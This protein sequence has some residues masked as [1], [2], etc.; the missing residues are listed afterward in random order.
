MTQ[1]FS[2]EQHST[3]RAAPPPVSDSLHADTFKDPETFLKILQQSA[4]HIATD[5]DGDITKNDLI[6]YS[7]S[8]GDDPLGKAAAAIAANHFD[9]LQKLSDPDFHQDGF[10]SPD[11]LQSDLKH[12]KGEIGLE[13][14]KNI[15]MDGL[16]S[17]TT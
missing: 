6:V 3:E 5:S 12:Y 16:V 11:E 13:T 10:I 17:A 2:L 15:A 8:A 4:P 1:Q 14:V 7:Q 9:Q